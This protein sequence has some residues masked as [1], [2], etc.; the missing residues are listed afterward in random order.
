MEYCAEKY[1]SSVF[2]YRNFFLFFMINVSTEGKPKKKIQRCMRLNN[3]NLLVKIIII[4]NKQTSIR[5]I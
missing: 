3:C 1:C 4:I 5:M 2:T